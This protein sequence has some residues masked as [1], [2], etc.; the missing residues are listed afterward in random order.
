MVLF[1]INII[2]SQAG[3]R[4]SYTSVQL[5]FHCSDSTSGFNY[6][7]TTTGIVCR[8]LNAESS[9]CVEFVSAAAFSVSR[10]VRV[11]K[12]GYDVNTFK[13]G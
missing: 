1:R 11:E 12:M 10:C 9:S 5:K 7:C 13:N 6:P 8:V 3:K 4:K 2:T